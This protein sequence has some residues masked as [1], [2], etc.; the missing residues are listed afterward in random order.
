MI[1]PIISNAVE[2]N[3][4]EATAGSIFN[5]LK[6]TGNAAPI[7]DATL[8]LIAMVNPM[9]IAMMALLDETYIPTNNEPN[10]YPNNKANTTLS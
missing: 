10:N 4:A 3:G 9:Q 7:N 2:I 5:A 1:C 8:M 6:T